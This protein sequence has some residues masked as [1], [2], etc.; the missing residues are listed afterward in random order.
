M[1]LDLSEVQARASRVRLV[2]LDVDG[3]LTDG[4]VSIDSVGGEAKPFFIRDGIGLIWARRA[5]IE[6]G[7]LSGRRSETTVRRAAE[8]GIGIVSQGGSDKRRGY[9]DI[10][11]AHG[12]ADEEVAYM[13]DDILDL[14]VLGRVGLSAAPADAVD[15]VRTRVHW[16]SHH[17]GGR[18][19][20]RE[21]VE[22]ILKA[23]CSWDAILQSFLP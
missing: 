16:V 17:T 21:F 23:R 15:D 1:P 7:L 14:P 22:L 3:V 4:T 20:V 5:G 11:A 2:L 13:A 10:L 19:A 6:V 9:A 18:G 12:Y 8:L